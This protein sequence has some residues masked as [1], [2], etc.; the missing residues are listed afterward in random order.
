MK[1]NFLFSIIIKY[2]R[3]LLI[4]KSSDLFKN[5]LSLYKVQKTVVFF[6]VGMYEFVLY[7]FSA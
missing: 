5:K 3:Y 1:K 2:I 7:Y 4:W 6:L